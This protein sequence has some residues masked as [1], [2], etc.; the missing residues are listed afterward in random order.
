VTRRTREAPGRRLR[1]DEILGSRVAAR[2]FSARCSVDR[3]PDDREFQVVIHDHSELVPLECLNTF[4]TFTL[5]A[6]VVRLAPKPS[7]G[8]GGSCMWL[9]ACIDV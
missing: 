3:T 4:R 6:N 9:M 8:A 2:G 7:G 5:H 1:I